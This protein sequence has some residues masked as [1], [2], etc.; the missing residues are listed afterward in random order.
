MGMGEEDAE[1]PFWAKFL[2]SD[3]L[4]E[5]DG[6]VLG[7]VMDVLD[8]NM[9]VDALVE[10]QPEPLQLEAPTPPEAAGKG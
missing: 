1:K 6:P 4:E 3:Y 10:K 5:D 2:R 8:G 7:R 9:T